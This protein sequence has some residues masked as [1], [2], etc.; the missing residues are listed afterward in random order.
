M[1]SPKGSARNS[2]VT[3][4]K[5]ESFEY[6]W[7]TITFVEYGCSI[8]EE[9]IIGT[10]VEVMEP[11][12]FIKNY[13]RIWTERGKNAWNWKHYLRFQRKFIREP[14]YRIQWELPANEEE[15]L[16]S[17]PEMIIGKRAE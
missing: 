8:N 5:E 7:E 1:L 15:A 4:H 16:Y 13:N 12:G 11:D 9:E 2:I 10:L 6:P 17:L 14:I 3:V